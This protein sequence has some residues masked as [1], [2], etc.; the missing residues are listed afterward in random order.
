MM[1]SPERLSV[2]E[3]ANASAAWRTAS[4]S[5]FWASA[6]SGAHTAIA[7]GR[8][9][10]AIIRLAAREAL[11]TLLVANTPPLAAA[12]AHGVPVISEI[13][14]ALRAMPDAKYVGITGT[15]GKTTVT[16]MIAHLLRALGHET[17]EAGNIGTALSAVAL[18][19]QRPACAFVGPR[20]IA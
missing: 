15:N 8:E 19:G 7:S 9:Q 12:R 20:T 1:T 2:W 5:W 13:E 17:V 6:G 3:R 18:A 4:R 16:A 10:D 11:G 14:V